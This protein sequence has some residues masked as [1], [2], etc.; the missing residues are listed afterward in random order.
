MAQYIVPKANNVSALGQASQMEC[1]LA[2]YTMLLQ[3]KDPSITTSAVEAKL[4]AGGFTAVADCKRRGLD[5]SQLKATAAALGLGYALPGVAL[6]PAGIRTRL[7]NYGAVWL[8]AALQSEGKRWKHVILVL[9][10]DEDRDQV[11]IVNPWKQNMYDL[12][13]KA[14]VSYKWLRDGIFNGTE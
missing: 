4:K 12:P 3:Q 10:L 8:A 7:H 13:V 5:D 11:Y 6:A 1:W 14:W 2:C 9:G